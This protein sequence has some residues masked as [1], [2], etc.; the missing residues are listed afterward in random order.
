[1]IEHPYLI[2]LALINQDGK[3]SMPIGGKSINS[4]LSIDQDP[5]DLA[6]FISLELLVRVFERLDGHSITSSAGKNSFLII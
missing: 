3:R 2:A 4:P 5:G 6:K 1:M